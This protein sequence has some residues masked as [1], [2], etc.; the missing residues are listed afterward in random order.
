[1]SIRYIKR[2]SEDAMLGLW[3]MSESWQ[4]LSEQLQLSAADQQ[5]LEGKKTESRKKEWLACR[6]LLKAMAP[7]S[8]RITYD[9]NRKPHVTGNNHFISMSHSGD[10][11]SV[12]LHKKQSVGVDIQK[13]KNSISK[14]ADYFL[15]S[16]EQAWVDFSDN[17]T[18]HLIW[19]AKESG[20][21]YAGNSE[22]D[23]KKHIVTKRFSGNQNGIIEVSIDDTNFKSVMVSYDTFEDYVLTW[24]L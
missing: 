6:V 5:V 7:E 3:Q 17:L 21:K 2:L 12:Y 10:F 11:A 14:G 9:E 24:T 4:E 13:M 20:F 15:H 16:S 19:S 22:L 8:G 23:L 18:M 1:M